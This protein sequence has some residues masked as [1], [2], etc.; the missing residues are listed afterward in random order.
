[1]ANFSGTFYKP[2]PDPGPNFRENWALYFFWM[3]NRP[4]VGVC[5][6]R[7]I[8]N[9]FFSAGEKINAINI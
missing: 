7:T 2:E 1:M 5:I 6:M 4:N 9:I 8:S 3:Q